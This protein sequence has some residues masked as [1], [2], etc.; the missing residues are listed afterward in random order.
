MSPPAK[1]PR[2]ARSEKPKD[3]WGTMMALL[4]YMGRD[5]RS[6]WL[7]MGCAIA[8]TILSLIGPQYL[9]DITDSLSSS[10]LG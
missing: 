8:S 3:L 10:I 4:R 6:L 7:G 1:G 2:W 5:R 9:A